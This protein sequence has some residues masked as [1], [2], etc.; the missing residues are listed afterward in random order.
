MKS[1]PAFK[2]FIA[3]VFISFPAFV[4]A[5]LPGPLDPGS[6]ECLGC[7]QDA[8][9][10]KEPLQ[11]CHKGDC[12]HPV[13]ISYVTLASKN[14]GLVPPEKLAAGIKLIDG[15]IGCLTCHIPYDAEHEER[16][17][18]KGSFQSDPMLSVDNTSS[19]LCTSCHRK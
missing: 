14:M 12:D 17:A 5:Q 4:S 13:G 18:F 15:K 11:V 7:H 10:V 3:A 9:A 1:A 6:A 2:M 19:A 8:V 16:A